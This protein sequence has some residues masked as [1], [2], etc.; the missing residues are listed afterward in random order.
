MV[1][2]TYRPP[3]ADDFDGIHETASHWSV[4]RQLGSWPWPPDPDFTR[5]RCQPY[6]GEGFV[7]SIFADGT[8]AGGIAVTTGELG[9]SLSPKFHRMGIGTR[10]VRYALTRAFDAYDWP[11]LKASCWH[12]NVASNRLLTKS[13]FQHWQSHYEHSV[14]R[15][16]P[17]LVYQFRLPR[18]RWDSLSN[19]A[20]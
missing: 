4:V 6:E 11:E 18:A 19:S 3:C 12:D 1:D 15:R 7:L 16:V 20:Q 17:T 2:L 10:A 8:Y 13:G 5:K 9:Y 14:A